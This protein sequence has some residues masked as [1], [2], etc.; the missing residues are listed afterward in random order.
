MDSNLKE[1]LFSNSQES[2]GSW[3][4]KGLNLKAAADRLDWKRFP[5]EDEENATSFIGV[6]KMLLGLAFE[7]IL[8]GYI[9]L[10]RLENNE[11]EILP[12]CY[13]I[14]DLK[15]LAEKSECQALQ[16]TF[17][18]INILD[19][20]SAYVIWAGCYPVPKEFKKMQSISSS[21]KEYT[22]TLVLWERIANL[23]QEKAFIT[24]GDR[25]TITRLYMNQ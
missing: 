19:G 24:Q 15:K 17:D 20:F 23:L 13:L 21:S 3:L 11:V 9:S 8:K 18:E 12:N 4:L 25:E 10:I 2:S 16:M 14:H 5:C 7:N 22:A 6:Y 1:Q